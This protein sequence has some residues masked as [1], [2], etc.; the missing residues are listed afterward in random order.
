M[1]GPLEGIR[2]FD[3]TLIMVGPWSTMN[4]GALGADV[5]HIERPGIEDRS[6]G[7]GIP[8]YINGVSIGH[9][10]WNM[11][12]RQMF[13]DLKS[14]F[15][16][17]L[18]H[19]LLATCDVFVDNMRPGVAD[20]LGLSYE[21]LSEINPR[22][23]YCTICGWGTTGPMSDRTAADPQVQAFSGFAGNSGAPDGRNEV[24]RHFTQMDASTGNYATMAILMALLA[25]ERTGRGQ[26]IDLNMIQAASAV[27]ASRI[28][29]Y[30]ATGEQP[31]LLGS[32]AASVAP[33]EAFETEDGTWMGVQATTPL[34]WQGLCGVLGLDDLANDERFATIAGRVAAREEIS[35]RLE[36]A[37]KTKPARWW[38]MKLGR[39]GVPC[40]RIMRFEELINHPQVMQNHYIEPV[41]TQAFG[42]VYATGLPWTF[43]RTPATVLPTSMAGEHTG[44][45]LDELAK[46]EPIPV[47]P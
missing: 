7:G 25:R 22:L 40:A 38:Q 37:F 41:Q 6:L 10:T 21:T 9:I 5:I 1:R 39:A 19:K 2:V 23:V 3:L 35:A 44:E 18:A 31:P 34:Q 13:L 33:S 46:A 16:V 30:L 28:G 29:E 32:A 43:S 4:L 11:N 27:Q 42:E 12:K 20:R 17:D 15:D 14:E 8:P 36:N 45:I 24:Y 26:R 47:R